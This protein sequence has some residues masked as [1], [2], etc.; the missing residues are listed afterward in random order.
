[1]WTWNSTGYVF[2][3]IVNIATSLHATGGGRIQYED[4]ADVADDT[5]ERNTQSTISHSG[6]I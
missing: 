5:Y 3:I 6:Q 4:V 1:M 2:T